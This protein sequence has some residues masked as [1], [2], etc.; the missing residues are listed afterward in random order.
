M[1][2]ALLTW[3]KGAYCGGDAQKCSRSSIKGTSSKNSIGKGCLPVWRRIDGS[4]CTVNQSFDIGLKEI[5]HI[6]IDAES[7]WY[8]GNPPA[9][10]QSDS[11][12]DRGS[13]LHIVFT[14]VKVTVAPRKTHFVPTQKVAVS[15]G[16]MNRCQKVASAFRAVGDADVWTWLHRMS[17]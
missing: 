13:F 10:A 16:F 4:S 3:L 14:L 17:V 9:L 12:E 7:L 6:T 2:S 15:H 11:R 8:L 5:K 1:I